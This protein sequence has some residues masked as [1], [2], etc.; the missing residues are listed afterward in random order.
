MSSFG[1]GGKKMSQA[2]PGALFSQPVAAPVYP[3]YAA[4]TTAAEEEKKKAQK[5]LL[6]MKGRQ[7]TILTGESTL[8]EPTVGK[9]ALLGA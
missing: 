9:R 5:A 8:G 2:N 1:G 3:S 6:A 4:D 7:S